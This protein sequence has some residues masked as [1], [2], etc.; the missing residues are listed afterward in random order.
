MHS[1]EQ[2]IREMKNQLLARI[3]EKIKGKNQKDI[4]QILGVSQP[5]VSD[6]KNARLDKFSLSQLIVYLNKLGVECNIL[7]TEIE[8]TG[9][10]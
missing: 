9:G 1:D 2:L 7:M 10:I 4:S 5:R 3:T 6:L 8:P